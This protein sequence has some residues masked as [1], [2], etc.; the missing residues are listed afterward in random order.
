[1]NAIT[2]DQ[3]ADR[4]TVSEFLKI[5]QL[6]IDLVSAENAA[7]QAKYR[8]IDK[9]QEFEKKFGAIAHRL[10]MDKPEH[11]KARAYTDDAYVAYRYARAEAY[12]VKR[13][14]D[15]AVRRHQRGF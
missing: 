14:L 4:L 11:A 12:N 3:M 6:A 7:R 8:Y 15:T 1:M 9:I 5:A 2:L 10:S 13:R